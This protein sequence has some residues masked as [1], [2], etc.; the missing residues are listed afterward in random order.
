M[1]EITCLLTYKVTLA[2]PFME[3]LKS[4]RT[5]PS[6]GLYSCYC[7][8][9]DATHTLTHC[10]TAHSFLAHQMI[11]QGKWGAERCPLHTHYNDNIFPAV[12]G[13]EQT[14]AECCVCFRRIHWLSP[15]WPCLAVPALKAWAQTPF[16]AKTPSRVTLSV[17][18]GFSSIFSV[19]SES[20]HCYVLRLFKSHFSESVHLIELVTNSYKVFCEAF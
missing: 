8:R 14:R 7:Y 12:R 17:K 2:W 18:V 11:Q 20:Y 9:N 13:G 16:R 6:E 19:Q 1:K 5:T 4:D 15:G 10:H 3:R